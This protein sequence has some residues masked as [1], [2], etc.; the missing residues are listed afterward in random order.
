MEKSEEITIQNNQVKICLRPV[1]SAPGIKQ[2]KFKLD[3]NKALIEVE[4]Y[5]LKKLRAAADGEFTAD[6]LF[7]YC[8]SGFAPQKSTK[9]DELFDA[10]K[11]G[12]EL[13]INYSI[14]EAWG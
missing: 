1:G 6:S 4:L 2:Q 14:Q 9:L 12:E 10:F 7:L 3:G 8:G 5:L 13:Q 11:T